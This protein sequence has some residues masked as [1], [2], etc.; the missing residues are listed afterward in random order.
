M[1]QVMG[2]MC[3]GIGRYWDPKIPFMDM[4][5]IETG[6]RDCPLSGDWGMSYALLEH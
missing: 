3:T 6:Y 2:M 5:P 1:A 4:A